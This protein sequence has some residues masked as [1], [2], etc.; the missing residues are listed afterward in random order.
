MK[1]SPPLRQDLV[2]AGLFLAVGLGLTFFIHSGPPGWLANSA[3]WLWLEFCGM[4]FFMRPVLSSTGKSPKGSQVLGELG[5]LLVAFALAMIP[6]LIVQYLQG[7]SPTGQWLAVVRNWV[8]L[9]A[10]I[11]CV[12]F[13][14]GVLCRM[15]SNRMGG[16]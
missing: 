2:C 9:P 14:L 12:A 16:C 11:G 13:G 6:V 4:V 1:V 3:R 7:L 8:G 15:I 5:R 10:G